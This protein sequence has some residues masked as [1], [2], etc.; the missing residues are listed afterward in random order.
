[1][2][3]HQ[4]QN[5]KEESFLRKY[6]I[7][8]LA[9]I[10]LVIVYLG[11]NS[12]KSKQQTKKEWTAQEKVSLCKA[13][14]A[15]QFGKPRDIMKLERVDIKDLVYISYIRSSDN[16]TWNYVCEVNPSS[17]QWAG[18]IDGQWGRWRTEDE[19]AISY[20]HKE[21]VACTGQAKLDTFS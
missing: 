15:D 17:I 7:W 12:S 18:L 2:N 3:E 5:K 10:I 21:K 8:T 19:A 1:M 11:M 4:P 20:D 9:A 14:I 16:T 13:Y 6:F